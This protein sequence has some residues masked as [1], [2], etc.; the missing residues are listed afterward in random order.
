MAICGGLVVATPLYFTSALIYAQ[1]IYSERA[2]SPFHPL[3][4]LLGLWIVSG[5][6]LARSGSLLQGLRGVLVATGAGCTLAPA[7]H[8]GLAVASGLGQNSSS[9][10]D[11]SFGLAAVVCF[12]SLLGLRRWA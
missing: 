5:A 7:V 6:L 11:I 12:A 8:G 10:V 9:G 2:E 4:W 1:L 3:P